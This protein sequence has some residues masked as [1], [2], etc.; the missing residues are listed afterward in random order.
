MII[1]GKA[2][3]MYARYMILG[4]II[5]MI[6]VSDASVLITLKP[7]IPTGHMHV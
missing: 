1:C 5:T 6:F 4:I 2:D 3:L 7:H